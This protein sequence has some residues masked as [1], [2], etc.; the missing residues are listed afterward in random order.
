MR[1]AVIGGYGA[2][3]A[4]AARVL[5]EDAG[6]RVRIGGRDPAKTA[7]FASELGGCA[8]AAAVDV[9]DGDS[10]HRFARECDVLLYSGPSDIEA[11]MRTAHAAVAAGA[12]YVDV[13]TP[14]P[15]RDR[16]ASELGPQFRATARV[17]ALGASWM[18]GLA[19]L[20]FFHG[21]A[22]ARARLDTIER[23]AFFARYQGPL[24]IAGAEEIL[25]EARRPDAGDTR[26]AYRGGVWTANAKSNVFVFPEPV[27]KQMVV[28]NFP[29]HLR[30]G[31]EASG[32]QNQVAHVAF[33]VG[34]GDRL[35]MALA[36]RARSGSALDAD[37][38][39]RASQE[40]AQRRSAG[41]AL[42][43]A[44]TGT[45][46][47]TRR[48]V[49]VHLVSRGGMALMGLVPA[50]FCQALRAGRIERTGVGFFW[51]LAPAEA[52][53]QPLAKAGYAVRVSP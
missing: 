25:D 11:R 14:L 41:E 13:G 32:L 26:G 47:G 22:L 10:L 45:S 1:V 23:I 16:L 24:G 33:C 30:Q 40:D 53:L 38:I 27:G 48:E 17:C 34:I 6:V 8:E 39:V 46:S 18:P 15:L 12:H 36:E 49:G 21:V 35:M 37:R 5:A 7:V 51:D 9:T 2:V 52:I 44:A 42:V 50:S 31:V 4:I 29:L 19:E 3:G 43:F 20:L 28:P